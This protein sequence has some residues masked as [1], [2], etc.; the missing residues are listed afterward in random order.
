MVADQNQTILDE[1]QA[2]ADQRTRIEQLEASNPEKIDLRELKKN[3]AEDL[4]RRL[5][6][7]FA[8]SLRFYFKGILPDEAGKGHESLARSSKKPKK[9]DVNYS[10]PQIGL[11]LGVSIKTINFRD[12][13]SRR[14][15]KNFTRVDNE[16]RAEASDYHERQPY[17]VL[18]GVLFLPID[19][20]DDKIK[21]HSS[22]AQ[23]VN[24]FRHRAARDGP[25]DKAEL[26]EKLYIGLYHPAEPSIGDVLFFDVE[27]SPPRE[28]IPNDTI[29]FE[30]I[31]RHICLLYDRRNKVS[32]KWEDSDRSIEPQTMEEVEQLQEEQDE[33][34]EIF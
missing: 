26:F 25:R 31:I 28:D 1:L 2:V 10:N 16:W 13:K 33:D 24:I 15:T 30:D 6:Q 5:A 27:R 3:Y 20:A 29:N 19:S 4:S 22:F 8:N 14:Y 23:G 9:L 7:R 11:G 17:A 18:V 32:M 12:P 21:S 34:E